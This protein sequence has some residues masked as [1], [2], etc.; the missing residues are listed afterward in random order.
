LC[1]LEQ[2]PWTLETSAK[3]EKESPF[4]KMACAQLTYEE[5]EGIAKLAIEK[6]AEDGSSTD[7]D[8]ET[9]MQRLKTVRPFV[10][11]TR[12]NLGITFRCSCCA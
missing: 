12:C 10:V 11:P 5:V 7:K 3:I 8:D 1:A 4:S 2:F 6:A 9:D